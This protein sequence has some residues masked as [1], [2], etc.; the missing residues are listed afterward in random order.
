MPVPY[1]C[2]LDIALQIAVEVTRHLAT[3]SLEQVRHLTMGTLFPQLSK[4][5]PEWAENTT[6]A[7]AVTGDNLFTRSLR[8]CVRNCAYRHLPDL[9]GEANLVAASDVLTRTPRALFGP[10]P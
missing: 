1:C 9:N 3:A 2:Q 7:R 4:S 5:V 8:P 10:R 6:P